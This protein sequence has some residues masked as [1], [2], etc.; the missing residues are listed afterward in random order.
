MKHLITILALIILICTLNCNSAQKKTP[1]SVFLQN[2]SANDNCATYPST[3]SSVLLR[4]EYDSARWT[5]FVWH[6]DWPYLP[7]KGTNIRTN[8]TFGQLPLWFD[9]LRQKHDTIEF[10]FRFRDKDTPIWAFDLKD[11]PLLMNGVAFDQKTGK[12]LYLI[13][14]ANYSQNENGTTSRFEYLLQPEVVK[15]IDSNWAVL[16]PCFRFLANKLYKRK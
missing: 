15:Y 6:C 12:K 3:L 9:S 4:K 11:R 10:Y 1:T 14:T 5:L 13:S 8:R 16:D 2:Q 7:N